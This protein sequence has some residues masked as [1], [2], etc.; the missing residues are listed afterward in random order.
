MLLV[1]EAVIGLD[2]GTS[3]VKAAIF[4]TT[5]E[6]LSIAESTYGFSTPH[7]GWCEQDP[8]HVWHVTVRTMRAMLEQA[9]PDISPVGMAVASQSGTLVPVDAEGNPVY[10]GI[11]WMDGRTDELVK[12]WFAQSRDQ[13][14]RDISGW[15]IHAGLPLATIAW[16]RDHNPSVFKATQRWLCMN[17]YITYKL[18]QVYATNPSNG[19][20]TQLMEVSFPNWS[21]A[22]CDL[23]GAVPDQLSPIVPGGMLLGTITSDS[24]AQI[25]LP[26]GMPV[27]CGGHDQSCTALALGVLHPGQMLLAC[28]TSW[29]ITGIV[30]APDVSAVPDSMDLNYH[31]TANLWTISQS[32]GGLGASLE[33]LVNQCWGELPTRSDRYQALDE[34]LRLTQPGSDGLVFIPMAGGHTAPAGMQRGGFVNLHLGHGRAHMARAVMESAAFEL[35]LA[36]EA[37]LNAEALW[38]FGGATRSSIWHSIVA[39]VTGLPLRVTQCAHLPAIGAA[40]MASI[41][42]G[43]YGNVEEAQR[44]FTSTSMLSRTFHPNPLRRAIYTDSY[45]HYRN[46]VAS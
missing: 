36:L 26:V 10:P 35:R 28:G 45:V 31:A 6:Q 44:C 13:S 16:L 7:P 15:H 24:G 1:K 8:D 27:I 41:G 42:I 43:A 30:T 33:W 38:M 22:L 14:V 39:D 19:G 46:V 4:L 23:A 9:G 21:Q 3:S 12:E 17:D 29:V 5:G 25:G 11:T 32:L 18:T 2:I 37:Q 34:E 20:V 40:V